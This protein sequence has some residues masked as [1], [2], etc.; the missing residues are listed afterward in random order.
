M[1]I[2]FII[3]ARNEE[4][5]IAE[6]IRSILTQKLHEDFEII[7]VDNHSSDATIEVATAVSRLVKVVA[8]SDVGTNP[9]RQRGLQEAR[10]E[11]VIFLDA[12]VRLPT[13]WT[14]KV[15]KKLASDPCVVAVSGPYRFYDFPWFL[16][17][18]TLLYHF[19]I[20]V[21]WHFL[22]MRFFGLPGFMVGG[23]MTIKKAALVSAGGFD[24][25][26]KFFGD[27]TD[28]GRRLRSVGRVIF[29]T[30]V[31]VYS[32]ARRFRSRGVLRTLNSYLKNYFTLLSTREPAQK[33][34][35]E[36]IR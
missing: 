15:L 34:K 17:I 12:D 16:K 27:D 2:S 4:K 3:P 24:T 5:Y 26:L 10:G 30:R 25:S 32:S 35:Y 18:S 21:P 8:E 22:G 7:V 31:W 29:S 20:T 6:C 14:A 33:G 11:V 19:L 36:E 1:S 13:G 9:A 23:N 28:T